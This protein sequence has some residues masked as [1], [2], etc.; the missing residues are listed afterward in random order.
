MGCLSWALPCTIF[1][2]RSRGRIL[3][4]TQMTFGKIADWEILASHQL[5]LHHSCK[6]QPGD[7]DV[8]LVE[9]GKA[10]EKFTDY[11]C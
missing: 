4:V 10:H 11:S 2:A 7:A 1:H 9:I 8:N 5:R 3:A 6:V